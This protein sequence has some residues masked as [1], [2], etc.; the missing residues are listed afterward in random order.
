MNHEN[1]IVIVA[2]VEVQYS[3]YSENPW[4]LQNSERP[5]APLS[6]TSRSTKKK[7]PFLFGNFQGC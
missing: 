1:V 4:N 5:A 3:M 6:A 2:R 7:E